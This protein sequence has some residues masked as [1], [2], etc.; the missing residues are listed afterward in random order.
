MSSQFSL[1]LSNASR[2]LGRDG[3]PLDRNVALAW[4]RE[5][6]SPNAGAIGHNYNLI[7][8]YVRN[9]KPADGVT[10][11]NDDDLAACAQGLADYASLL[12]VLSTWL[13]AHPQ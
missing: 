13:K 12:A 11:D 10:A 9:I 3:L 6:T 8:N 1:D 4:I 5:L 7:Y 2:G